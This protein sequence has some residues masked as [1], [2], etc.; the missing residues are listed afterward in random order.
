MIY[1]R[2]CRCIPDA[3]IAGV[4]VGPSP[5]QPTW[6]GGSIRTSQGEPQTSDMRMRRQLPFDDDSYEPEPTV[7]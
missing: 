6:G 1:R 2:P 5:A 4:D 7:Q 3:Q